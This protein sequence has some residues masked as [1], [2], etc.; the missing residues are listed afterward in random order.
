MHHHHTTDFINLRLDCGCLQ[1]AT[2]ESEGEDATPREEALSACSPDG[3]TAAATAD[4]IAKAC[5]TCISDS[6][7]AADI[8]SPDRKLAR[9]AE[10]SGALPSRMRRMH[11]TEEFCAQL[12]ATQENSEQCQAEDSALEE[13]HVHEVHAYRPDALKII[14]SRGPIQTLVPRKHRHWR[15]DT[16]TTVAGIASVPRVAGSIPVRS[17]PGTS[18]DVR[19]VGA[20]VHVRGGG[21]SKIG[22]NAAPTPIRATRRGS[23]TREASTKGSTGGLKAP[24]AVDTFPKRS[25]RSNAK[26]RGQP[27]QHAQRAQRSRQ[28]GSDGESSWES[29]DDKSSSDNDSDASLEGELCGAKCVAVT[30][31]AIAQNS[32][33]TCQ[34]RSVADS[35]AGAST[36]TSFSPATASAT[37]GASISVTASAAAAVDTQK[38]ADTWAK[39]SQMAFGAAAE[40]STRPIPPAAAKAQ[41]RVR[42]ADV[43]ATDN[44]PATASTTTAAVTARN[45]PVSGT[46]AAAVL[47][48]RPSC[49]GKPSARAFSAHS[50]H[51]KAGCSA[52]PV[53]TNFNLFSTSPDSNAAADEPLCPVATAA[54]TP[55]GNPSPAAAAENEE[56]LAAGDAAERRSAEPASLDQENTPAVHTSE[57]AGD[58]KMLPA[59]VATVVDRITAAAVKGVAAALQSDGDGGGQQNGGDEL[60]LNLMNLIHAHSCGKE[61]KVEPQTRVTRRSK[62]GRKNLPSENV[63]SENIPPENS[64]VAER[65]AG[66]GVLGEP[67]MHAINTATDVVTAP[68]VGNGSTATAATEEFNSLGEENGGDQKNMHEDHACIGEDTV[69]EAI[70]TAAPS[71]ARSRWEKR[72]GESKATAQPKPVRQ[73]TSTTARLCETN[74]H[75]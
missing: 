3:C 15:S 37:V 34:R 44:L 40:V 5:G 7:A 52:A 74:K 4:G 13:D 1:E 60:N 63:P 27:S 24:A 58:S 25:T 55:T 67:S 23:Y 35:T 64:K 33:T 61:H 59:S 42:F 9:T 36:N 6:R 48:K 71:Q 62:R 65:A 68:D 39:A 69:P 73:Q 16:H 32:R 31:S 49:E 46:E 56:Q 51:E 66:V 57:V 17:S 20:T 50:M 18:T 28:A 29:D 70:D 47:N 45:A 14:P 38:V 11:A 43:A 54:G 72:L 30:S 41:R 19:F 12:S 53:G 10:Q 75:V 22:G 8:R 21:V 26:T 2:T